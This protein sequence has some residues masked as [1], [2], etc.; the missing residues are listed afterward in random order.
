[1][2]TITLKRTCT[3]CFETQKLDQFISK[4]KSKTSFTL[5]CLNC[6]DYICQYRKSKPKVKVDDKII[7]GCKTCSRCRI[8]QNIDEFTKLNK[9]VTRMCYA[10]R[11]IVNYYNR[12]RI[13][14]KLQTDLWLMDSYIKKI[15]DLHITPESVDNSDSTMTN[16]SD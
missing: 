2:E 16:T 8:L 15:E 14:A 6:R 10:C 5:T 9:K 4:Y 13:D 3:N 7:D 11:I 1:M 12:I